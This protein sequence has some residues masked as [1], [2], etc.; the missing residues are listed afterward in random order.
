MRIL[1]ILTL[2]IA[3]GGCASSKT[4]KDEYSVAENL[5]GYL[6][7]QKEKL[8]QSY[9]QKVR[10]YRLLI[11]SG[12]REKKSPMPKLLETTLKM[13]R[14]TLK[15]N[16]IMKK[17]N[18]KMDKVRELSHSEE[19]KRKNA[20]VISKLKSSTQLGLLELKKTAR[21]YNRAVDEFESITRENDLYL[22]PAE[23][24]RTQAQSLEDQLIEQGKKVNKIFL[25]SKKNKSKSSRNELYAVR[26]E[27]LRNGKK[28][29]KTADILLLRLAGEEVAAGPHSD[30]KITLDYFEKE[31]MKFTEKVSDF[32]SLESSLD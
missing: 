26:N 12:L 21:R 30:P 31:V 15:A 24:M 1:T 13:K 27:L 23:E 18:L 10:F 6:V 17:M 16:A 4:E 25:K 9:K 32:Q 2:A 14:Q 8:N 5:S 22:I 20:E 3:I 29:Q 11:K 28:I 19:S 7:S